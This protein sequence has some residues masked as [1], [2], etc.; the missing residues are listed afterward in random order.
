MSQMI[1]K[2]SEIEIDSYSD[3]KFTYLSIRDNGLGI[4]LEKY[5]DKLFG[6]YQRL[7]TIQTVKD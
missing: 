4:D 3:K 5:K 2:N 1:L 6:L 7:P